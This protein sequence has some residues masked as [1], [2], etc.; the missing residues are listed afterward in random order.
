MCSHKPFVL[1]VMDGRNVSHLMNVNHPRREMESMEVI[2]M[3]ATGMVSLGKLGEVSAFVLGNFAAVDIIF[4]QITNFL[5]FS[6]SLVSQHENR[7]DRSHVEAIGLA[8]CSGKF[9]F[10][11]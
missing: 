7:V 6:F 10:S 4:K 3:S 8:E 1:L 11:K 2:S 9:I 5:P